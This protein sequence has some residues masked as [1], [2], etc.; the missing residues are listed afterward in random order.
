MIKKI[1]L[2]LLIAIA[3]AYI[4]LLTGCEKKEKPTLLIYS[5]TGMKIVMEDIKQAFEQKHKIRLNIIYA[6]SNTLLKT[7]QNTKKGDIY[8]PG[9][10][11]FIG[12]AGKLVTSNQYV[13][14]HI[15]TFAVR[16]DNPKNI[17]SFED[18]LKPGVRLALGNKSMCTLG[19]IVGSILGASGKEADFEKNITMRASTAN[20][21]LNLIINGDVDAAMTWTDM[22]TWPQAKDLKMIEIPQAINKTKKIHVAVLKS[23][24]APKSANLFANFIVTE[25]KA[26]FIKHG[27]GEK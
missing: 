23:T 27:F 16:I 9:S 25:G 22:L 12:K 18:L 5:G 26:I 24:I 7:I 3:G 20:E 11:T 15:P 2:L 4:G 1:A 14:L 19:K 6:G 17:N 21:M 10:A 13:A 8:I